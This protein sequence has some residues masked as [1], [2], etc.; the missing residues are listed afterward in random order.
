LLGSPLKC[1]GGFGSTKYRAGRCDAVAAVATV[2]AGRA[3]TWG[4]D[5]IQRSE[6]GPL[7]L[8]YA[9]A[10][11]RECEGAASPAE[12][13][14]VSFAS[15][16]LVALFAMGV[17]LDVPL[18]NSVGSASVV[19]AA[20]VVLASIWHM[21]HW[22]RIRLPPMTLLTLA[23]FVGWA[24]V[25]G[26]W[27]RDQHGYAIYAN[28]MAQLLA[29]VLLSWQLV[30]TRREVCAMLFG[31]LCG[32]AIAIGAVWQAF[33]QNDELAEGRYT[34]LG[35][36]PNDLAVTLALGIPMA[37]YVALTA[38]RRGRY[39]LLTYVPAAASAVALTGSRGGAL[40]A[41]F[42]VLGTIL[43][44]WRRA[45]PALA[46]ASLVVAG[47]VFVLSRIPD[48]TLG[49][50]FT[51]GDELTVGT[52]GDRAQIWRAGVDVVMRHPF[53]GVGAG[54]FSD[55]TSS[56]LGAHQVAHNTPISVASQLGAVGFVLFYGAA[57]LALY[58]VARARREERML[59]WVLVLTWALGT[60]SLTWEY[61]KTTWLVLL[62]AAAAGAVRRAGADAGATAPSADGAA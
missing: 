44:M 9:L 5:V 4:A 31:Y 21:V 17:A 13:Q 27:A 38:R 33:L 43:Y 20:P 55:A 49:R 45:G 24:I 47:A 2:A 23:V 35:Y 3:D 30:R 25:S 40:T 52:V 42:A 61:R 54:G 12:P 10:A 6:R 11:R 48:T 34:G 28:T 50:I 39:L 14:E 56:V 8:A 22:R 19:L 41:C 16:G 59:A 7:Y 60:E 53:L 51:A 36:D 46:T 32:C 58:G 26:A 37:A 15:R 29:A 57:A 1:P 18:A 62:A